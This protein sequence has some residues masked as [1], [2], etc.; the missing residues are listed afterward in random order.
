LVGHSILLISLWVVGNPN[1]NGADP[2]PNLQAAPDTFEIHL[3]DPGSAGALLPIQILADGL[4]SVNYSLVSLERDGEA[5]AVFQIHGIIAVLNRS[6]PGSRLFRVELNEGGIDFRADRIVPS[7][8][9]ILV[10]TDGQVTG[11]ISQ[12]QVKAVVDLEAVIG[13]PPGGG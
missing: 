10:L 6:K 7:Q 12:N 13:S 1:P 9:N 3:R 4:N 8:N 2:Y 5:V 11:I